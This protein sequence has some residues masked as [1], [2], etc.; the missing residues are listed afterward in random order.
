MVSELGEVA[1][2]ANESTSYG[3]SPEEFDISSDEIGDGLFSLLALADSVGID[4]DEALEEALDKYE[5]R[6]TDHDTA[7]SNN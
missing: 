2:D 7:A 6:I 3:R 5:E 4:A 1:K